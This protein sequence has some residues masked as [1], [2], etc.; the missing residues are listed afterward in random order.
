[1]YTHIIHKINIDWNKGHS[2]HRKR[3]YNRIHRNGKSF[4][5]NGITFFLCNVTKQTKQTTTEKAPPFLNI[6]KNAPW[7]LHVLKIFFLIS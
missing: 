1:M 5:K 4:G 2:I 6:Q 7:A 3:L